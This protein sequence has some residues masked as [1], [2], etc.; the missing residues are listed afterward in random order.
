MQPVVAMTDTSDGVAVGYAVSGSGPTLIHL[1]GVPLSNFIAE[2]R[3]PSLQRAYELLAS[4]LRFVQYDGRG[5]GQSQRDVG[6]VSLE[7][8]LTD[9]DAVAAAAGGERFALL[10]FYLSCSAAVAYAARH[11]ERV[12]GL[13]LFGGGL[14]GWDLMRGR[15]TQ[16]LISLIER[17]WSTFAESVAH[18][19]LGWPD[20][21]TGALGAEAFRESTTPEIAKL[22]MRNASRIDVSAEAAKVESPALVLHRPAASG[23]P[24]AA[25]EALAAAI[26]NCRIEL[27]EGTSG[28]LFAENAEVL[29]RRVSEFVIDPTARPAPSHRRTRDLS[30]L[31]GL[32]PRELQVLQRIA[33]GDS[34]AEI[35]R[36]L[37]LSINT[38]ERHVTNLYRKLDA[39]SRTEATAFAIRNHLA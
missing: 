11:P 2:W 4:R 32:S 7:T 37:A 6:D 8:M 10:G 23:V 36:N 25:P 1:P 38:V 15:A 33:A 21:V 30:A 29:A 34:N 28:S 9:L 24:A 39:R 19:W 22:T 14:R 20:P 27:I 31:R 35:A 26:P 3:I 18:A 13:L 16:A 12:S 5:T 17:D